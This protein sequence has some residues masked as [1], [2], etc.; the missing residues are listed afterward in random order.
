[1]PSYAQ[2][3]PDC[4]D[5]DVAIETILIAP[6]PTTFTHARV[7]V[8]TPP[9]GFL[10][11]GAAVVE[12]SPTLTITRSF[13]EL[14]T[15]I[16]STLQCQ[17]IADLDGEFSISIYSQRN[18]IAQ[19]GLGSVGFINILGGATATV[20]STSAPTLT[21]LTLAASPSAAWAVGDFIVTAAT[22]TGLSSSQNEAKISSI[23]GLTVVLDSAVTFDTTPSVDNFAQKLT[24]NKLPFGTAIINTYHIIG[25]ADFTGGRQLV[26]DFQRAQAVGEWTEAYN[27]ENFSRMNLKFKLLTVGTSTYT[28]ASENIVG[29]RIWFK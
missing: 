5:A 24:G 27:T 26:H 1:M 18:R 4:K 29:E 7:D 3:I 19:W 16:P 17:D 12:D 25:V 20:I 6:Y 9:A 23:N 21:Q 2:Q 8:D 10:K 28:G 15:G 13:R 22:T 11:I 14:K